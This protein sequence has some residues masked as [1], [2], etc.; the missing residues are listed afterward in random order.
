MEYIPDSRRPPGLRSKSKIYTPSPLVQ[1]LGFLWRFL[2]DQLALYSLY[3]STLSMRTH[4][5]GK[6]AAMAIAL[7]D[8]GALAN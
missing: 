3:M 5:F 7:Y 8:M 2:V 4:A 1:T 6:K